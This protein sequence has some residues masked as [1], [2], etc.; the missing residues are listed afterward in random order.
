MSGSASKYPT[1]LGRVTLSRGRPTFLTRTATD[2]AAQLFRRASLPALAQAGPGRETDDGGKLHAQDKPLVDISP[3]EALHHDNTAS[4]HPK[5]SYDGATEQPDLGLT[6]GGRRR[7][8]DNSNQ[9]PKKS[10]GG[11]KAIRS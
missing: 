3:V 7:K 9:S 6:S 2:D 5:G 8:R 11:E 1:S 4:R 10:N